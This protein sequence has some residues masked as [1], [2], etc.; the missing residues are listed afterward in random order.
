MAEPGEFTRRA[1]ENGRLDLA[2]GEAL[3]GLVNAE[4]SVQR[5][6]ALQGTQG[7]QTKRFEEIRETLL[8]AMAMVEALIDFSDED[9]VEEGTWAKA[10]ERV[11]ALGELL[12]SELGISS[13]H[14]DTRRTEGMGGQ[15]N[16]HIR[17]IG[18]I[19]T[20][21]VR[22]AI[23]GPPNA[24]KS[25]LLNRLADRNA[26][27]VSDIPGTTRDVLQVHLDL[28]GYKVIVYDTAGIRDDPI[29]DGSSSSLDQIERIGIDRAKQVIKAAD[30]ALL[31]LPANDPHA[32]SESIIRPDAYTST[33]P[34]LILYNK[35][36]LLPD[37]HKSVATSNAL[38][39]TGSVRTNEGI[40]DLISSLARLISTK[41]A[42]SSNEAPLIT[43]SRHRCHLH[44]CLAHID[45]FQQMATAAE[46]DLVLAAEE[47]RYAAK[48]VGKV[49]GRDVSPDEILGSIFATFCIGK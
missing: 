28:G 35:S 4:T 21:G 40:S 9:G 3:G 6:V 2:S 11:E 44:E 14:E 5:K 45:A 19:L 32:F 37:S 42:L 30:L 7:L 27:I 1:F 25:S 31:V 16:K 39:F 46:P 41:Y 18:E 26:A 17:H 8:G 22:L 36:D 12:R 20:T 43:Q 23:Y 33:D 49:T 38:T 24:G 13:E 34:D 15:E 10:R 48:A 29:L 47:L